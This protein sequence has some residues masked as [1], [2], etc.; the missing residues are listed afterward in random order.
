MY[1]LSGESSREHVFK[2]RGV[3]SG[4]LSEKVVFIKVEQTLIF[5]HL[6]FVCFGRLLVLHTLQ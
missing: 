2:W 1:Y 4:L 6:L 5:I 3:I